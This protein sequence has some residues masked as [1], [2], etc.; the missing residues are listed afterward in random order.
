MNRH[1][2]W[3]SAALLLLPCCA[4]P[5]RGTGGGQSEARGS[6]ASW[7][8]GT[9][10]GGAA[11]RFFNTDSDLAAADVD[12]SALQL[13]YGY[14]VSENVEIN[15]GVEYNNV[16]TGAASATSLV[17][18]AGARY[19]LLIPTENLP[20]AFYGQGQA[21]LVRS[22]SGAADETDPALGAA[23]GAV[24]WPWGVSRGLAFDFSLDWLTSESTTQLGFFAGMDF[25]F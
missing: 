22:D 19:Y 16:D 3:T 9:M 8:A 2:L 20:A 6:L 13:E 17:G 11:F 5:V 15:G 1:P 12:T 23:A 4:V 10:H 25:W 18:L 24:W 21:G 7:G 14:L